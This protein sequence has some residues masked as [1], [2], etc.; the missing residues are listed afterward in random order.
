MEDEGGRGDPPRV[1]DILGG[2][3]QERLECECHREH[4]D[5]QKQLLDQH[6]IS[7]LHLGEDPDDQQYVSQ[8]VDHRESFVGDSPETLAEVFPK[9]H[10][11]RPSFR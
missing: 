7:E 10:R 9:L 5:D 11:L 2:K 1:P 8:T 3:L 4:R 6:E